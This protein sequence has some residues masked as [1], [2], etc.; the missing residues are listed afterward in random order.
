MPPWINCQGWALMVSLSS[1]SS[2]LLLSSLVFGCVSSLSQHGHGSHW[3]SLKGKASFSLPLF[4][5]VPCCSLQ[6]P[7]ELHGG[8]SRRLYARQPPQWDAHHHP[9]TQ[10]HSPD[11][12]HLPPGQAA[13]TCLTTAHGGGRG[14]GEPPGGGGTCWSSIPWVGHAI[15]PFLCS[16]FFFTPHFHETHLCLERVV[17]RNFGS[18]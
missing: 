15:L 17:A 11:S 13:Q 7:G 4:I 1:L 14:S 9:T 8:R 12:H 6:V 2:G 3:W 10:V 18:D 16:C 5:T